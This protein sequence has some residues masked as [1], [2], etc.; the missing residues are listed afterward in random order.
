MVGAAQ[1]LGV[2]VVSIT[3]FAYSTAVGGDRGL[4]EAADIAIDNHC[5]PGDALVALDE[6]WP[7]MAPGSTVAGIVILQSILL[8]A[9]ETLVGGGFD[10]PVFISANMPGGADHNAALI[11]RWRARNPHL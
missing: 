10:L 6:R 8:T 1:A 2:P 9:A 11:E 3:S 5:P 4:A 7:R